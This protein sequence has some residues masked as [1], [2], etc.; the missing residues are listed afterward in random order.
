MV[1]LGHPQIV[2]A[3]AEQS[4][5]SYTQVDGP[6]Y[7]VS[8]SVDGLE[9]PSDAFGGR[10]TPYGCLLLAPPAPSLA[11]G[12]IWAYR[13]AHHANLTDDRLA[14]VRSGTAE[15]TLKAAVRRS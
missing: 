9:S 2:K 11:Q 10:K 3:L 1:R 12:T 14:L 6:I 13:V 7:S 15:E 5:A 4:V 8:R